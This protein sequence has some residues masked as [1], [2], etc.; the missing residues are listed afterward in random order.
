[1]DNKLYS[2][3]KLNEIAQGDDAFVQELVIT[4]IDTVSEETGNIQKLMEVGDWKAIGGIAHKLA[5][6]YAYMNAESLYTLAANIEKGIKKNCD[7]TEI[8]AMTR[9]MC[10]DSLVLIDEL[11]K[12][13]YDK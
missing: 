3:E 13:I 5:S 11:R 2:F 7:L 1:M 10:T 9:Q 6:N 12:N 4:F 8:T